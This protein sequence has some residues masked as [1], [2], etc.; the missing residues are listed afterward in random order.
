VTAGGRGADYDA[1]GKDP[2]KIEQDIAA[3]RAE[4]GAVIDALEQRL[5]PRRLMEK[6][7]E[8]MK[9]T[10][11][12]NGGAFGERLR[13]HPV[14]LALIGLGVGWFLVAGTSGSELARRAARQVGDEARSLA[15]SAADKTANTEPYQAAEELAGYAYARTKPSFAAAADAATKAASDARAGLGRAIDD[16]P[17]ALALLGLFAGAAIGALL[18]KSRVEE[19]VIG[20]ARERIR[21]EATS[22]GKEAIE[23]ARHAAGRAADAAA[24]AVKSEADDKVSGR[25]PD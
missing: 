16:Y 6:G 7:M 15:A 25:A 9:D 18:P 10:L 1:R 20:P 8:M 19:Q 21:G 24:D 22:L 3:T 23:R 4:L 11:E 17:L 12:G 5:A 13:A 2:A 14:P